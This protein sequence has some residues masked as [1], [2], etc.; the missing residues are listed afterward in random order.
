MMTL[1]E[2]LVAGYNEY[3]DEQVSDFILE[4]LEIYLKSEGV[5]LSED[6]LTEGKKLN[7]LRWKLAKFSL[8]FLKEKSIDEFLAAYFSDKD[9]NPTERSAEWLRKKKKEKVKKIRDLADM[10][11]QSEKDKISNLEAARKLE[12]SAIV[13]GVIGGI[14]LAGAA[15]SA[16][17]SYAANDLNKTVKADAEAPLEVEVHN[18]LSSPGRDQPYRDYSFNDKMTSQYSI[19]KLSDPNVNISS[20]STNGGWGFYRKNTPYTKDLSTMTYGDPGANTASYVSVKANIK[21]GAVTA[22][23]VMPTILAAVASVL[24]GAMWGS[25]I[26][27]SVGVAKGLRKAH[28]AN[29][30]RSEE[31]LSQLKNTPKEELRAKYIKT[32]VDKDNKKDKK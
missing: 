2:Q 13:S 3:C 25:L 29:V 9:G 10:L 11:E 22:I 23:K 8:R 5:D 27:G 30:V 24:F 14:G 7:A 28:K 31:I 18:S 1:K 21:S 4:Q 19:D 6:I 16:Y 15:A 12:K 20:R 26:I 17:G 32:I